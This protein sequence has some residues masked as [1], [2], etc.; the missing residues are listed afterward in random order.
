MRLWDGNPEPSMLFK[1]PKILDFK[2]AIGKEQLKRPTVGRMS[3]KRSN[4]KN[5]FD[6]GLIDDDIPY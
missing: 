5:P 4:L 6:S 2:T 3:S 1:P